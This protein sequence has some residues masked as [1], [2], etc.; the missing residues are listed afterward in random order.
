MREAGG[1]QA[2]GYVFFGTEREAAQGSPATV[3]PIGPLSQPAQMRKQR[4]PEGTRT[5]CYS[6]RHPRACTRSRKSRREGITAHT[7]HTVC[8][9]HTHTHTQ[10]HTTHTAHRH[11]HTHHTQHTHTHNTHTHTHTE[12]AHRHI[13]TAHRH[14]HTH[15]HTHTHTHT[16]EVSANIPMLAPDET[17][18]LLTSPLHHY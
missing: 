18:I 2:V 7:A 14:I 10:T 1:K 12:T 11:I 13:H 4:G 3:K 6:V 9:T 15:Q 8:L 16:H 17:V 5:Q